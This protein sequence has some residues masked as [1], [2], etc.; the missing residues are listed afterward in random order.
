M[1]NRKSTLRVPQGLKPASFSATAEPCPSQRH[2]PALIAK[3][4]LRFFVQ[5]QRPDEA[6]RS[7]GARHINRNWQ[8]ARH[9]TLQVHDVGRGGVL[10]GKARSHRQSAE[11]PRYAAIDGAVNLQRLRLDLSCLRSNLHRL[12]GA[13]HVYLKAVHRGL[14]GIVVKVEDAGLESRHLRLSLKVSRRRARHDPP[15]LSVGLRRPGR[16]VV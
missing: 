4:H 2:S 8:Y 12:G 9:P 7:A 3:S 5:Y 1:M 16:S 10:A 15:A 13:R 14:I 6:E 11:I